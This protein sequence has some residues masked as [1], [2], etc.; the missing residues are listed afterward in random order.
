MNIIDS[1]Q[2]ILQP[3]IVDYAVWLILAALAWFFRRLPERWRIDIEARHRAAL[4]SALNTGVG[5]AI[6][7]LQ[8]HP[9]IAVP[10]RTAG[11]IVSYVRQSV[12]GAIRKLGPSQEQL[13]QMAR[14]KL[15][16]RL[17]T[18]TGRDRLAEALKGAGAL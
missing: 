8:R 9:S 1:M 4:H 6:D 3:I 16:E 12:P 10:D 7:T 5:L 17:D 11:E 13:E 2:N 18:I 15:Q 14:A